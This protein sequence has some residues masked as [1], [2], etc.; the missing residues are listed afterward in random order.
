MLGHVNSSRNLNFSFCRDGQML[1]AS[2]T[3]R[4]SPLPSASCSRRLFSS[5]SVVAL[6]RRPTRSNSNAFEDEDD[7]DD[8]PRIPRRRRDRLTAGEFSGP[9]P[10]KWLEGPG[11]KYKDAFGSGESKWLGATGVRVFIYTLCTVFDI[12]ILAFPDE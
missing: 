4:I 12:G 9:D 2:R 1:A 3:A 5:T 6:P 10:N 11:L 7:D 8:D